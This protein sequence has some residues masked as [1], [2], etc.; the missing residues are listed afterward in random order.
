MVLIFV[1]WDILFKVSNIAC[2]MP[3]FGKNKCHQF[4]LRFL[5]E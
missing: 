2:I 1:F 3:R 5:N 4:L